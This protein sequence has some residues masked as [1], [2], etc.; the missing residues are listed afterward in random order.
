MALLEK[1]DCHR[2]DFPEEHPVRC[3]VEYN[4]T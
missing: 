4:V 3:R 1:N 2:S